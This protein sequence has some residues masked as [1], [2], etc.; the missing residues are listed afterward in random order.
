MR[1]PR[2]VVGL[3]LSAVA[4]T[5]LITSAN[6]YGV[7]PK[8]DLADRWAQAARAQ[9]AQ[10]AVEPAEMTGQA[11]GCFT[12]PAGDAQPSDFPRADL[13]RFCLDHTGSGVALSAE[14]V[15]PTDPATDTNWEGATGVAWGLDT[16]GDSTPEFE[17]TYVQGRVVVHDAA[18]QL[19]CERTPAFLD[20]RTY[21][22]ML[23]VACVGGATSLRVQAFM[24][25]DSNPDDPDAP[26]YEDITAFAG[27]VVA[28]PLSKPA[29]IPTSRLAGTD[30]FTT[31]VAISKNAFPSGA[32]V[33]YVARADGYADALAGG[34]LTRGPILLV[35]RC[36]TVPAAVKAEVAR[37]AP[38]E[39]VA[40]GGDSAVCASVL[41]QVAQL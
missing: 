3:T 30:R 16:N 28:D 27:P 7:A 32:P 23:P 34:T 11:T 21:Y 4:T 15:Q 31:A 19:R 26:V 13:T 5:T 25:Y 9:Q 14:A 18:E 35:P 6:A 37:L 2:L 29:P 10:P 8:T 17:V 41:A 38:T 39:I 20:S 12:D 40:L 22:V 1:I 36:G 33:V 24:I